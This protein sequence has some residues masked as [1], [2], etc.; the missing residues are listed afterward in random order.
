MSSGIGKPL[1]PYLYIEG[2]RLDNAFVSCTVSSQIGSPATAV[3]E[4]TPTE[5]IRHILPRSYVHIFVNDPW[6]NSIDPV[7]LFEGEVLGTGFVRNDD[8]RAFVIHCADVSNYWHHVRQFWINL[9]QGGGNFLDNF[10]QMTTGG[11]GRI[12]TV[13]PFGVKGYLLQRLNMVSGKE[14]LFMNSLIGLLDDIGNISTFYRNARRRLRITDRIITS[15]A[16]QVQNLF[17]LSF[18]SDWIQQLIEARSGETNLLSIISLLLNVIYHEF[19]S[20]LAPP[21]LT[22]TGIMRDASGDPVRKSS[23]GTSSLRETE[24]E[25]KKVIGSFIFKPHIY[26]LPPPSCNVLFPEMYN[27]INYQRNFGTEITR[28]NLV[29]QVADVGSSPLRLL[30]YKVFKRPIELDTFYQLVTSN[31]QI[32]N[33]PDSAQLGDGQGQSSFVQE[34][35]F[36]TN[37]ERFKGIV[38]KTQ[39]LAPAPAILSLVNQGAK[40]NDGSR[41]GGAPRYLHNVAS[42]EY[43]MNKFINRTFAIS[44]VFNIR[45]IPGYPLLILDDSDAKYHFVTYLQGITHTLHAK[46]GPS[47][48][49][50]TILPREINEADLN[51]PI[52]DARTKRFSFATENDI[53]IFNFEKMFSGEQAP[54]I[55]DWFDSSFKT[56]GALTDL[57]KSLFGKDVT[58]V[59]DIRNASLRANESDALK[60]LSAEIA[61]KETNTL[62][63][64]GLVAGQHILDIIMEQYAAA[65]ESGDVF[66]FIEQYTKRNFT[67]TSQAFHFLGAIP[68]NWTDQSKKIPVADTDYVS[69]YLLKDSEFSNSEAVPNASSTSFDLEGGSGFGIYDGKP[70]PYDFELELYNDSVALAKKKNESE[71]EGN[72]LRTPKP[73]EQAPTGSGVEGK[74]PIPVSYPLSEN[75]IIKARRSVINLYRFELENKRGFRG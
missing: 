18:F 6:S 2:K 3:I 25:Q 35:D 72:N 45:P 11:A 73:S 64:G 66:G 65:K 12:A 26:T 70:I 36:L 57:Y 53:Q 14:N 24:T 37:E 4:L 50:T 44:G 74:N 9:S 13:G 49:Y 54:P 31:N 28:M 32:I 7:L 59:E 55:P 71:K 56:I 23:G 46:T 58:S 69:C 20:V 15:N 27:G 29:P 33:R 68:K 39:G 51:R 60:K 41:S 52:L 38:P 62:F 43:Y 5:T 67:S 34:Y 40:G 21:Y 47:T 16:G 30:R 8:G 22:T 48:Q 63:A 10:I 75:E 42:Y 61:A 1:I 19:V 17:Q